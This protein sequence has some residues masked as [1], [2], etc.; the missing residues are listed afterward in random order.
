MNSLISYPMI[1]G[2]IS[3]SACGAYFLT[4]SGVSALALAISA[5]KAELGRGFLSCVCGSMAIR[6]N[7]M[8]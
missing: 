1:A 3:D 7:L 8:E 5:K 2:K 4:I 6:P